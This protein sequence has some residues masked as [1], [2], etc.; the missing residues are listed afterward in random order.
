MSDSDS[1]YEIMQPPERREASSRSSK[2]NRMSKLLAEEVDNE[3]GDAD[4][5]NQ[6]FWAED[7]EDHDFAAEEADD[8]DGGVD[9]FDSDFGDSTDTESDEV[10]LLFPSAPVP[11]P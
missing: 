3:E 1:E 8:E 9:S 4:F 6:G 10:R 7:E 5:Y 11:A 2:G